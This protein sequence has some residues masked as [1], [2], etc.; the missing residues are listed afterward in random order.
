[1]FSDLIL[2]SIVVFKKNHLLRI[3]STYSN[4]NIWDMNGYFVVGSL[5]V[6]LFFFVDVQEHTE[7]QMA[8]FG[9][10]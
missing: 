1:M 9:V 2:S 8:A 10:S 5:F 7:K 6:C 4:V 3:S